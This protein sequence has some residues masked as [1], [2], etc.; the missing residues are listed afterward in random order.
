MLP[1]QPWSVALLAPRSPRTRDHA[2]HPVASSWLRTRRLVGYSLIR[3]GRAL[4][5]PARTQR[6]PLVGGRIAR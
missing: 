1:P 2:D 6:A 3:L 5:R 4:S